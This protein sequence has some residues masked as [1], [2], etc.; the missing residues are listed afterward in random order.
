MKQKK[1]TLTV[2]F[3]SIA[4]FLSCTTRFISNNSCCCRM[5]ISLK[6]DIGIELEEIKPVFL[7]LIRH[8][9]EN[10]CHVQIIIYSYSSSKDRFIYSENAEDKIQID[11]EKGIIEALVKIKEGSTLKRVIF[12][13]SNGFSRE[14]I[15]Y[16]LA[17]DVKAVL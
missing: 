2:V 11:S 9:P 8:N 7:N 17:H 3:I 14:E 5:E 15:I 13:K 12:L 4:I 1:A 16:N 10:L 6:D